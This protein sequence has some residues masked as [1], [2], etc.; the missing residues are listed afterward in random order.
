MA[1]NL[2]VLEEDIEIH[3]VSLRLRELYS[4]VIRIEQE[5]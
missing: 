3:L 4:G 2:V 5:F 1:T